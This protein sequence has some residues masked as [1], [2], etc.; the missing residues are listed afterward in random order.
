MRVKARRLELFK[1]PRACSA[2]YGFFARVGA[3]RLIQS[4]KGSAVKAPPRAA[5]PLWQNCVSQLRSPQHVDAEQFAV[6][7][8]RHERRVSGPLCE[9]AKMIKAVLVRILGVDR[10][11][12]GE[13]EAAPCDLRSLRAR[14]DQMH[15]NAGQRLVPARVM[16]E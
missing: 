8:P 5:G 6:V 15:L 1:S 14:A 10:L 12:G 13:V 3:W 11:A 9:V 4:T 16:V 7:G 2:A